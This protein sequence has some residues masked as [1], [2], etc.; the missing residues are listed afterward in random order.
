[1]AAVF[2]SVGIGQAQEWVDLMQNPN[3]NFYQIQQ[4]FNQYWADRD[5]TEKGKGYKQFKRP[6][7][8]AAAVQ[9]R[10]VQPGAEVPRRGAGAGLDC[11]RAAPHAQGRGGAGA[12][13]VL[14]ELRCADPARARRGPARLPRPCARGG[15]GPAG[16][17]TP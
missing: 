9:G 16:G 2:F 10:A 5:I 6:R 12:G 17:V 11:Q 14:G 7:R 13:A 1:M 4:S 8:G 15:A 3:S